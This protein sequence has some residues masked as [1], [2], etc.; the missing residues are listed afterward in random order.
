MS[1]RPGRRF[2]IEIGLA[3]ILVSP[4]LHRRYAALP[5]LGLG[6]ILVACAVARPSLLDPVARRWL[7]LAAAVARVTTP[8]VLAILYFMVLT[9][10]AVLRRTFGQS[11]LRRDP[12]AESYWIVLGTRASEERRARM[13]RQF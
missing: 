5:L 6:V 1:I 10:I 2:G 13:G 9:P 8:I 3:A 4:F 7:A 11:P 12:H